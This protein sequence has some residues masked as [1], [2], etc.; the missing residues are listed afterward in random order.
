MFEYDFRILIVRGVGG[1]LD[2]S[3]FQIRT[4]SDVECE[5]SEWIDIKIE[6]ADSIT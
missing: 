5:W 1:M 6:Y 3:V 2:K 4:R